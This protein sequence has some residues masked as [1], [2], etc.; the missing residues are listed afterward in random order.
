MAIECPPCGTETCRAQYLLEPCSSTDTG[1]RSHRQ[2]LTQSDKHLLLVLSRF[3]MGVS[4]ILLRLA[5][6]D[7]DPLTFNLVLSNTSPHHTAPRK[8]RKKLY[9]NGFI[10]AVFWNRLTSKLSEWCS[11]EAHAHLSA[12]VYVCGWV[13]VC[14]WVYA[15][16]YPFLAENPLMFQLVTI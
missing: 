1:E 7:A 11:W 12:D 6:H 3:W 4:T 5:R 8:E 14:V 10:S 9:G 15:D 2:Y 16:H 13:C